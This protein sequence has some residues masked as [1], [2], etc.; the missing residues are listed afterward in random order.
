[1]TNDNE[2]KMREELIA[3]IDEWAACKFGRGSDAYCLGKGSKQHLVA[4]YRPKQV[5]DEMVEILHR[6]KEATLYNNSAKSICLLVDKATL[7][8]GVQDAK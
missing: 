2:I 8:Q 6:I 3:L 4:A 1:M 5:A 7:S